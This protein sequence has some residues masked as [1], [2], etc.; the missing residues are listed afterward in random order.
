LKT[1]HTHKERERNGASLCR[2]IVIFSTTRAI[3]TMYTSLVSLF[4]SFGLTVAPRA[5]IFFFFFFF[6][7]FFA[8]TTTGRATAQGASRRRSSKRRLNE[9]PNLSP[10]ASRE[11]KVGRAKRGRTTGVFSGDFRPVRERTT[12]SRKTGKTGEGER[13]GTDHHKRREAR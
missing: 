4:S 2:A 11:A 1:T 10:G 13:R 7:F 5:H 3:Y 9:R 12:R 6:F 8:T